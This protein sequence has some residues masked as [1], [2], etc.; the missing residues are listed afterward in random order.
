MENKNNNNNNNQQQTT[1]KTVAENGLFL[2]FILSLEVISWHL[3][4]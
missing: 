1:A 2:N 4:I 3:E